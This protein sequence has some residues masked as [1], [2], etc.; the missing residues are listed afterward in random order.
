VT[1]PKR[2][3]PSP[4]LP[5]VLSTIHLFYHADLKATPQKRSP[6]SAVDGA[7]ARKKRKISYG[8]NYDKKESTKKSV[9]TNRDV[10]FNL[11]GT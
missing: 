5:L 7:H 10:M 1:T 4:G 6:V 8:V 9:D 2:L 3:A 11:N